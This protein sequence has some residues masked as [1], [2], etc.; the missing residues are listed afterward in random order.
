MH[1][2]DVPGSHLLLRVPDGCS[3]SDADLQFAA[4]LSVYFSKARE[5]GR[6]AVTVC[7]AKDLKKFKGAKPGQV[8]IEPG[9]ER[10]VTGMPD[11]SAACRDAQGS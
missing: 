4:D 10:V 7:T 9:S 2:R 3:A 1:A 6:C 11:N 8:L 5:S